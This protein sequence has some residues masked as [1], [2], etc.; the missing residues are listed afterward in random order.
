MIHVSRPKFD[1]KFNGALCFTLQSD[2]E[3]LQRYFPDLNLL[4]SRGKSHTV[5]DSSIMIKLPGNHL[6]RCHHAVFRVH[7]GLE[8]FWNSQILPKVP[9]FSFHIFWFLFSFLFSLSF[10]S[11]FFCHQLLPLLLIRLKSDFFLN[12]G[13]LL[14]YLKTVGL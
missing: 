13:K 6:N 3:D 1:E 9:Y 10:V 8:T 4:G 11:W 7:F 14:I 2:I 12:S 5:L